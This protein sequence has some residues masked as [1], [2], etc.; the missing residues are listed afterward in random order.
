MT[1]SDKTGDKLTAS[2]RKTREGETAKPD[3][4]AT[5]RAAPKQ[6]SKSTPKAASKPRGRSAKPADRGAGGEVDETRDAYRHGRR[7]WPD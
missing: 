6:A 4:D 2:I 7:V 3:S 1:T 5:R